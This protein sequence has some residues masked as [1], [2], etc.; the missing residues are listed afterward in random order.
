MPDALE[1]PGMLRAVI[2]LVRGERL[3]AFVGRVVG[4]F[5]A[6]RFRR[7][8]RGRLSGRRS[9]LVP[10]FA[11]IVGAL[12]QLA[13]PSA[14][15]RC[16]DAVGIGWRSLQMV[17]FPTGEVRAADVPLLA[18][19]VCRKNECAF[20]RAHQNANFAHDVLLSELERL[21]GMI[22]AVQVGKRV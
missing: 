20:T 9:G 19:A 10:G 6:R 14:C 22:G 7:A 11:T 2:E 15:L 5:I 16:V 8:G 4:E 3:T 1:L 21:S 13:E 12:N 18:L 17:E